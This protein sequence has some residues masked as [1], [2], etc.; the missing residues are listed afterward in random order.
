MK[1][2]TPRT[3]LTLIGL[4]L[5][6]ACPVFLWDGWTG[7]FLWPLCLG[8]VCIALGAVLLFL[9]ALQASAENHNS[10]ASGER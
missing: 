9:R 2:Y 8:C 6:C 5:A 10:G 3:V 1:S 4:P 7:L